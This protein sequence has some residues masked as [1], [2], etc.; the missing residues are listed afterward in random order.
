MS[1]RNDS[2]GSSL[3][4]DATRSSS[5]SSRPD[6]LQRTSSYG[7]G[8]M[9]PFEACQSMPYPYASTQPPSGFA[10]VR[11]PLSPPFPT[12]GSNG[13][14][15][16]G[17]APGRHYPA[18]ITTQAPIDIRS[19]NIRP[20][21]DLFSP[22]TVAPHA[23]QAP[24]SPYYRDQY[25]QPLNYSSASNGQV[26][27]SLPTYS[28][29]DCR[30]PGQTQLFGTPYERQ[31]SAPG[32]NRLCPPLGENG[33]PSLSPQGD[34]QNRP[35]RRRGN[36]PKTTT[37][38]LR[39]WLYEHTHH[40]YPSEDEKS[41]LAAQTGL[42]INQISNWFINARRRI[43]QPTDSKAGVMASP[44]DP[45]HRPFPGDTQHR[46]PYDAQTTQLPYHPTR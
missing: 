39:N 43:L 18:Y 26:S 36:L 32:G 44:V 29:D 6:S 15:H 1:G 34:A 2:T 3:F 19:N 10:P 30:A 31:L 23:S 46:L 14:Y 11:S 9:P 12:S 42:T 41:Q 28:Y 16:D 17:P 45:R 21:D 40:P 5:Y 27:N 38:L 22:R 13:N 4:T 20:A 37:T 35:K 8:P 33:Y 25:P 24:P 7:I